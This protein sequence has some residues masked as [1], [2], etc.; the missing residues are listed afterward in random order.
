MGNLTVEQILTG[1]GIIVGVA[2]L[3]YKLWGGFKTAV[4]NAVADQFETI[5]VSITGV[6]TSVDN[7]DKRIDDVDKRL[8]KVNMQGCKNFLVRCIADFENDLPNNETELERFW[9]QYDYYID[10]GE[11]SYVR[12]KVEYLESLGKIKRISA[13]K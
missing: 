11:N 3:G 4:V 12:H 13:N 9:E 2:V 1:G 5:K 6:Q 8:D 10:N 7:L